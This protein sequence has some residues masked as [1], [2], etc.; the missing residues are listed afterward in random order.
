VAQHFLHGVNTPHCSIL[1]AVHP[2]QL[3]S[4]SP[5]FLL[6]FL[7]MT[8]LSLVVPVSSVVITLQPLHPLPP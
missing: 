4:A 1:K 2:E 3:N 7:L 8:S 5:F 6:R